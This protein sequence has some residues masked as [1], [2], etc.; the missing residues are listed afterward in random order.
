MGYGLPLGL[1]ARQAE[2]G[3]LVTVATLKT[4]EGSGKTQTQCLFLQTE[5]GSCLYST[6]KPCS[7][8][9]TSAGSSV[10]GGW[11]RGKTG[12]G[13][14]DTL[15]G[16]RA[17]GPTPLS[18]TGANR[19]RVGSSRRWRKSGN[20][21]GCEKP[22]VSRERQQR[23]REDPAGEITLEERKE[24][25]DKGGLHSKQFPSPQQDSRKA[26]Q[27]K[28]GVCRTPKCCHNASPKLCTQ[29]RRRTQREKSQEEHE[30]GESPSS[31]KK[32]I[33]KERQ[34]SEEE[35]GVCEL[36]SSNL[37]LAAPNPDLESNCFHPECPSGSDVEEIREAECDKELKMQNFHSEENFSEK[38]RDTNFGVTEVQTGN[39]D[40]I[41]VPSGKLT[42][43]FKSMHDRGFDE[44]KP[45]EN[46]REDVVANVNGFSDHVEANEELEKEKESADVKEEETQTPTE[47]SVLSISV[48][49]CPASISNAFFPECSAPLEG[50]ICTAE[51]EACWVQREQENSHLEGY[52]KWEEDHGLMGE[53][54]VVVG[55]FEAR[56]LNFVAE[57]NNTVKLNKTGKPQV[58]FKN[59]ENKSSSSPVRQKDPS[60]SETDEG[61]LA[62]N[63]GDCQTTESEWR[64]KLVSE[65][66][67]VEKRMNPE[68]W[69]E[70]VEI[71]R[72]EYKLN[73][74]GD[75]DNEQYTEDELNVL[76]DNYEV[77]GNCALK[78]S[79][80]LQE[81][82]DGCRKGKE[83]D[84]DIYS[85]TSITLVEANV[86]S[87]TDVTNVSCADPSTSP[88]LCLANPAPS[89]PPLGSMATG[90]PCVVAEE[91]EEGGDEGVGLTTRDGEGGQEGK[92]RHG[93]ELE[94][95]G[96]G[97]RASIVATEEGRKEEE[98]EEDEFGVFMQAEGE[99]AWSEGFAMSASV[100]C[101]S[102][103]SV[104]E[105][106][107]C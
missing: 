43:D 104:G 41:H 103:E 26:R 6:A 37:V 7:G 54:E 51:H 87:S 50:S 91:E 72:K 61:I 71:W 19:A 1:D 106:H 14:R 82:A 63:G 46:H 48:S 107:D 52:Q 4:S 102:R 2:I 65:E 27:E 10:V 92:R 8:V 33:R 93:R 79:W 3:A 40:F 56:D 5:K 17:G 32:G 62:E 25:Q 28:E 68:S 78:D 80:R 77:E 21:A 105:S 69:D 73:D 42:D 9:T 76:E 59:E 18:Q 36:R 86:K 70:A 13:G 22:V 88:A 35:G 100:P 15:A 49:N 90:L 16:R 81:S 55:R 24:V 34:K 98:E 84:G 39:N 58:F 47:S 38:E 23:S 94:E 12:G 31:E 64:D 96:E 85:Q 29:C 66:D 89:L 83:E 20:A 101:G 53:E 11:L 75:N 57:E 95:Q 74:K 45:A 60:I 97:E 67:S 99:P 30:G 44:R